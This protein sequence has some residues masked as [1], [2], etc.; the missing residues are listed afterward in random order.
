KE[1]AR[2]EELRESNK[3]GRKAREVLLGSISGGNEGSF[4]VKGSLVPAQSIPRDKR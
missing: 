3:K 1:K 4:L 2:R